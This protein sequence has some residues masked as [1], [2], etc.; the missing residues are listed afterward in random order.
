MI[1]IDNASAYEQEEAISI[2]NFPEYKITKN[3]VVINKNGKVMKTEI[4]NNGYVR[5]TL[6]KN[7]KHKKLSIHRLVAEAFIPNPFNLPQVNHKDKNKRNNNIDNLE[8]C[9]CSYNL[10]YSG[11]TEKGNEAHRKQVVCLDT[12][13]IFKSV[14]DACDKYGLSHGNIVAC[15]NKRRKS[16][17]G[18][19]WSYAM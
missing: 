19:R 10:K 2:P 5:V 16:T 12:G 14:K 13:E 3:G 18:M 9:S 15:C 1:K 7:Q 4:S 6:F 17:G 11:V 8:W